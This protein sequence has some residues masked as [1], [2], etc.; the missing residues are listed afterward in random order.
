MRNRIRIIPS[1][2]IF[3]VFLLTLTAVR[4]AHSEKDYHI[5]RVHIQARL[6]P[7]GGMDIVES[8]TY[9][10]SESFRYAF[11]TLPLTEEITLQD[12]RVLE[13]DKPYILTESGEPGSY[14]ID[15]TSDGIKIT[16]FF[17]AE[18]ESKTFDL[19]F[20]VN[21]AVKRY[22]DVAV[23]YY[24]F[25][26]TGWSK[27]SRDVRLTLVPPQPLAPARISEW[28]HGPLWAESRIEPDGSIIAW[29]ESLPRRTFLEIR[30][31]YPLELFPD[32]AERPGFVRPSILEEETRWAEEANQERR[33]IIQRQKQRE[34]RAA[35]GKWLMA[36]LGLAGLLGWWQLFK[37]Y[38]RRPRIPEPAKISPG[39]PEDLPPA[40]MGY[41]IH[42]KE[43][44]GGALVGTLF[45]L[46]RRG[47]LSMRQEDEAKKALFGGKKIK[48][49][50]FWDLNRA[51]WENPSAE[52]SP[53][54]NS[55]IRFLFDELAEGRDTLDIK[56][57]QKK[58]TK[59]MKFFQ[60]W[61]KEVKR[62]G[63]TREWFDRESD[64]GLLY[65]LGLSGILLILTILSIF[66]FGLWAVLLG[67]A[68]LILFILSFFIPHRTEKGA[69]LALQWKALKRYLQQYHYRGAENRSVLE[70]IDDYFIY[71]VV[72]G[73]STKV[74]K[75]L[76]AFLPP[77]QHAAYIPWYVYHGTGTGGFSPDMFAAS[78]SSMI[79]TTTSAMSSASGA[80]G[81]ASSGGGGGAGGSGGGAG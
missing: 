1:S 7:D 52:L 33:R 66:Y 41:L 10:F 27:P 21:R 73:L 38:G 36:G 32:A 64:R 68:T 19:R 58:Q 75:E 22:A 70:R 11:Y 40:L 12:I 47:F 80:G 45:D 17:I 57:I 62:S 2:R 14:R 74:V 48:T 35:V 46:A 6:H 15:E 53:Y 60:E 13:N 54:E 16:W 34:E 77:E 37:K 78:F 30:A 63:E 39:I 20:R 71:G 67:G 29:C 72:F 56:T 79:A 23:F 18:D 42:H 65:S 31:L 59:F 81:G 3:L 69:R 61:K 28:L 44:S 25:I 4:F 8:R 55:L 5:S 76:A 26:G 9:R 50:Y 43:I 49:Q 24:K 51:N